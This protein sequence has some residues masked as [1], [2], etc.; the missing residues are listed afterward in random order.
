MPDLNHSINTR[1]KK[2]AK[3]WSG[4]EWKEAR[5]KFINGRGCA[6][7]GSKEYLT[8]HHPYRSSY[9]KEL[10]LDFYLSKCVVLCRKCHSALHAGKVLCSCKRGYKPFDADECF[11]CYS[12]K[13][14][15]VLEKVKLAKEEKK[16]QEKLRR[17]KAYQ[18]AKK[19]R[20]DHKVTTIKRSNKNVLS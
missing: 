3:I 20:N 6:W 14:P 16:R 8:V 13:Y 12:E 2:L 11:N 15:E 19:W 4:K 9:G 7:C 10:Y 5:L 1:K 17:K 18:K